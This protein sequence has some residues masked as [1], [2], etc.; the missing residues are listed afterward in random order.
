MPHHAERAV[1]ERRDVLRFD[2]AGAAG[3]DGDRRLAARG[4]GV[5]EIARV[6]R[7]G[8]PAGRDDD[9]VEAE[10]EHHAE[11]CGV[12][13]GAAGLLPVRV[14]PQVLVDVA[15]VEVDEVI[16]PLDDLRGD[17]VRGPLG[18]RAIRTP[19]IHAIHVLAVHRVEVRHDLRERRHVEQ[20]H[21][22]ERAGERRRVHRGRAAFR[23]R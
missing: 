9:V 1:D 13:G 6:L 12:L 2:R 18:L 16:A 4:R 8:R 22:D 7:V 15:A 14:R 10:R 21:D 17:G 20:R 23:A 11:R 3:L 19:G 5:L